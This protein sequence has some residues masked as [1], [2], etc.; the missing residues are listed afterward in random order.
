MANS[1]ENKKS[2]LSLSVALGIV[3]TAV[4]ILSTVYGF[5]KSVDDKRFLPI[6]SVMIAVYFILFVFMVV[7]SI[8]DGKQA[9]KETTSEFKQRN[10]DFK[11]TIK[12]IDVL[13]SLIAC[14]TS[15]LIVYATYTSSDRATL[16]Q[17]LALLS[18]GISLLSAIW[19][20]IKTAK[21]VKKRVDKSKKNNENQK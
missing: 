18:A 4:L 13:S 6:I 15:F 3:Q 10:K 14:V 12:V 9:V 16:F 11:L 20:G 1:K 8:K 19:T 17:A 21:K 7:I 2:T 5:T